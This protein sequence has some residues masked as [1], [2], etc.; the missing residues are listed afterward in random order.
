MVEEENNGNLG[1]LEPIAMGP[2][3]SIARASLVVAVSAGR[4][5]VAP[6]AATSASPHTYLLSPHFHASP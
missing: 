5:A 6:T 2:E 4:D 3:A 1:A